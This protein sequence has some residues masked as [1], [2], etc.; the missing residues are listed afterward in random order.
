MLLQ[1][2]A[3]TFIEGFLLNITFFF[4]LYFQIIKQNIIILDNVKSQKKEKPSTFDLYIRKQLKLKYIARR[5]Q[6]ILLAVLNTFLCSISVPLLY[7]IV[8]I[9]KHV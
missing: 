4:K 1:Y 2:V 5:Y 6:R 3:V 7:C 9:I 8:D